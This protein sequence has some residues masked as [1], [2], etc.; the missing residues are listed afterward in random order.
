MNAVIW[1]GAQTASDIFFLIAAIVAGL[2]TV[3]AAMRATPE[4][5][6]IPAAIALVSLGLLAL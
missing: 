1:S 4:S 3:I 2:A 5:A 6:L